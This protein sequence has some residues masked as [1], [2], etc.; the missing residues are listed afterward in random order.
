MSRVT[1]V[2]ALRAPATDSPQELR[3]ALNRVA[4]ALDVRLGRRGDPIDRAITLRELIDSGL[5]L[6]LKAR[7]FDPNNPGLDFIP[8]FPVYPGR[9]PQPTGVTVSAAFRTITVF[10]DQPLYPGHAF[11]EI[12][13]FDADTIGDAIL[14]GV[15]SSTAYTD[16]VEGGSTYYYWVRFVNQSNVI[17]DFHATSGAV[18]TTAPNVDLLL[19]MLTDAISESQLTTS[20]NTRITSIETSAGASALAITEL[21]TEVDDLGTVVG[22]QAT[23]ISAI[24]TT[25]GENTTAIETNAT[26]IDGIHGQYTVKIDVNGRVAG[27]GLSNTDAEYDGGIHSEFAVV[28]DRFQI[29][30][31]ADDDD[32][33]VPFIVTTTTTTLNGVS[34]PAGVYIADAYIRN[35]AIS[36]AKIGLLQVD[37]AQMANLAV[38]E[39]KIANLAVSEAKIQDAAITNAKIANAAIT[40]AKIQDLSVDTIKITGNAVSQSA[41]ASANAVTAVDIVFPARGGT[42]VMWATFYPTGTS[43]RTYYIKRG[44]TV[45]RSMYLNSVTSPVLMFIDTPG[46]GSVTYTAECSVTANLIELQILEVLK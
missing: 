25:V 37:T 43:A 46:T 12:W 33:I 2:P 30:S 42:V 7:P 45:L 13:R 5:A 9:P 34:V 8:P 15:S 1:K 21:E 36:T 38:N 39:A 20:L 22:A 18:G 3:L 41:F 19:D 16:I 44:S 24:Q 4:E 26:S 31:T 40:T 10:W 32:V 29:V 27:F 6:K 17:G 23:T 28:A 14:I 11:A 35:G